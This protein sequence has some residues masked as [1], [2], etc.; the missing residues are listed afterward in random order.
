MAEINEL[1]GASWQCGGRSRTLNCGKMPHL[2]RT[3]PRV[4]KPGV[5]DYRFDARIPPSGIE[6]QGKR[7]KMFS[8]KIEHVE[9]VDQV[10]TE[11]FVDRIREI[12]ANGEV[13]LEAVV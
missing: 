11:E 9:T 5:P 7:P 3:G 8:A 1:V 10:L 13:D 2:L 6:L 12:V 4:T